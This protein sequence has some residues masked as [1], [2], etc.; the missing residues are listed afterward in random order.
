MHNLDIDHSVIYEFSIYFYDKTEICSELIYVKELESL[1]TGE[2]IA[3]SFQNCPK[4]IEVLDAN[5]K[6][7]IDIWGITNDG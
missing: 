6:P 1:F 7:I 2:V 3:D 5:N 4:D